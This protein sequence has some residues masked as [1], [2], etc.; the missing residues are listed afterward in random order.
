VAGDPY[1]ALDC[2]EDDYAWCNSSPDGQLIPAIHF[3]H[4]REG[5]DDYRRLRT[6]ARLAKNRAGTPAALA[7]E[8]L[9]AN[10]MK[11][12]KLGQRNHDALFG[13][14]DWATFRSQIDDVI[15]ALRR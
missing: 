8:R 13:P 2:R 12:F 11:A 14:E 3:E 6:A 7:A 9:I 4:L 15:E 10:R 5:L 1:Y